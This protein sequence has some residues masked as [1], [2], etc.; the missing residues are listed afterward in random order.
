MRRTTTRTIGSLRAAA[1]AIVAAALASSC[2]ADPNADG[3]A[4]PEPAHEQTSGMSEAEPAAEA[5]PATD[6]GMLWVEPADAQALQPGGPS[7]SDGA[8]VTP[9][10][11]NSDAPPQRIAAPGTGAAPAV[12][13]TDEAGDASGAS[14]QP[15]L[16]QPAF[17][18][19]HVEWA[20]ASD[21][22]TQPQSIYSTSIT[23][24]GT[25][26]DGGIYVSYGQFRADGEYCQ[27]YHFLTPGTTAYAN[28][29]CGSTAQ[30]TRRLVGHFAGSPVTSTP[31]PAGGT[32]L[33]ATF[34]DA[35]APSQ[36]VAS[37]RMLF[38]LSAF[39]C[40]GGPAT[41]GCGYYET[42]DYA[43]SWDSYRI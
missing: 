20:P 40:A 5:L 43:H 1:L 42:L 2:S 17:D 7:G 37:G 6:M 35:A 26:R 19:V 18:I 24:A 29:F 10:P 21:V 41:M 8:D 25:A 23:V 31:T 27:L 34:N 36:L 12:D 11:S 39:T 13:Y 33:Q 14:G 30:G 9:E 3:V 38:E 4:A 15:A 32:M 22:G 28:A 16:S